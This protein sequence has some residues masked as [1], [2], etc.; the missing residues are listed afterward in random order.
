MSKQDV[1][2]ISI[3]LANAING[4]S[5]IVNHAEVSEAYSVAIQDIKKA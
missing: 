5:E 1:I 3:I 4:A 2:A